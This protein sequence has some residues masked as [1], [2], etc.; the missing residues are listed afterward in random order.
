MKY[1]NFE[2]RRIGILGAEVAG[3][4]LHKP[5][6]DAAFEELDHAL[7]VHQVLLFREQFIDGDERTTMH[8]GVADHFPQRRVIRRC[9]VD[10]E[11]PFFDPE[12]EADPSYLP[13]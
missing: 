8:R 5:L 12:R 3:L 11:A 13:A 9:T 2:T 1:R 4:D 6:S 10:G 7:A